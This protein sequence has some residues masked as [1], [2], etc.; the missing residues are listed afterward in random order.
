MNKNISIALTLAMVFLASYFL[1]YRGELALEEAAKKFTVLAF[2]NTDSSCN[3]KSLEFFVENNL[4]ETIL[5]E[6]SI[7][8]DEK[9][10][11]NFTVNIPAQ[12]KKL[13]RIKDE[14]AKNLCTQ[15]INI[16]YGVTAKNQS[17]ELSIYKLITP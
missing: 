14:L 16:K 9:P 11:K 12:D 3:G 6:I 13:I 1:Y 4:K 10:L 7:T 8:A 2:E 5:Y 15:E 17:N